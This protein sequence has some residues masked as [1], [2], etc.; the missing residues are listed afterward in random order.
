MTMHDTRTRFRPLALA[1]TLILALVAGQAGAAI[2]GVSGTNFEFT[3]KLDYLST[4]DGNSMQFWGFAN[5]TGGNVNARAQ[6]PG[7]TLILSQ[8]QTVTITLKNALPGANSQ[9]VSIVFPG[10]SVAAVGGVPGLLTQEAAVG[11]PTG[12][13]YT[14][15]ANQPGTYTYYSGTSSELQTEMGL[16]G[17][18][19]VRPTGFDPLNPCAYNTPASCY[20]HEYLFLLSEMAPEI[21]RQVKFYG[22]ASLYAQPIEIDP[23]VGPRNALSDY[24]SGYWF[25]NGRTAPDT[26]GM[27]YDPMFPTQPY[28][29]VPRMHPGETVLMRV[30]GGGREM[31][32]FH[33]HG[34][35]ALVIARDGRLLESAPGAGPD[36]AYNVFTVTNVPGQTVDALFHWTG[37][38]LGWDVYGTGPQYAHSCT[39][40]NGDLYDDV[41]SEW[42]PD[43]GKP[44]PTLMPDVGE[45]TNGGFWS[46]SPFMGTLGALPPGEGGLNPNAGFTYMWHSHNEKEL[47]NFDIFPGGMMTMLIVEPPGV[48][49]P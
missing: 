21:H 7:P 17:A 35:H 41:T 25:I 27:A 44:F 22:V 19:I 14:F 29:I 49:I 34:N 8:G 38:G 5:T 2:D 40:G 28:N 42:C 26:M 30:V 39:D 6:Y 33:H 45:L 13:T 48:P 47:T 12:V 36:L 10:Q 46:G 9:N 23:R 20:D 32:P 15:T 43:H 16:I 3:V 31:H 4:A 37:K 18:I 24:F 11:D 1:A